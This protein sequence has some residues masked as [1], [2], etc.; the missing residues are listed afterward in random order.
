MD[1]KFDRKTILAIAKEYIFK[2]DMSY[3][4]LAE[5]YN[6]SS[7]KISYMMNY[8]LLQYS[9]ILYVLA[10]LKAKHNL[11]QNMKRFMNKSN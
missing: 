4:K 5:K 10:D 6:C 7:S 2:K 8:D 11:K 1:T 9:R 3:R